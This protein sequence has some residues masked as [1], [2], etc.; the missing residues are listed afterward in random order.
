MFFSLPGGPLITVTSLP[1]SSLWQPRKKSITD[2]T[3]VFPGLFGETSEV[4]EGH[5]ESRDAHT[6]VLA[7]SRLA[8]YAEE[9]WHGMRIRDG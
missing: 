9:N 6:T 4:P 7:V 3:L 5:L 8:P 1:N 2:A